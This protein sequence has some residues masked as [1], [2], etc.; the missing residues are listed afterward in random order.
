MRKLVLRILEDTIPRPDLVSVRGQSMGSR[1]SNAR[2][3]TFKRKKP[4]KSRIYPRRKQEP[5]TGPPKF[6]LATNNHRK[7]YNDIKSLQNAAQNLL[8]GVAPHPF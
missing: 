3:D 1:L 4:K 7:L 5:R 8:N 6:V 2:T